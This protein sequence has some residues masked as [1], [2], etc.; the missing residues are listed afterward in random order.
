MATAAN[1][2]DATRRDV[3][4]QTNRKQPP[5][6]IGS[7]GVG[8]GRGDRESIE[9]R[10]EDSTRT[11]LE[12]QTQLFPNWTEAEAKAE[13]KLGIESVPSETRDAV[14]GNARVGRGRRR[15]GRRGRVEE[16]LPEQ[17]E[18][19]VDYVVGRRAPVLKR[20]V[21]QAYT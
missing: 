8:K 1:R 11:V 21:L 13:Q 9:R 7:I 18:P 5:F 19:A 15:G 12:R 16:A 20:Q 14:H 4:K 3:K 2:R 6:Q 10:G 17:L